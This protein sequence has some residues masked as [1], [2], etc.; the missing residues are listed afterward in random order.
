MKA[1]TSAK[2]LFNRFR[3]ITPCRNRNSIRQAVRQM[4]RAMQKMEDDRKARG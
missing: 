3:R 1:F 4:R 2:S